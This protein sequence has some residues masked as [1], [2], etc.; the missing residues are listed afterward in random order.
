MRAC[1]RN[2]KHFDH[3]LLAAS[4]SDLSTPR[5]L[6]TTFR[7]WLA[8]GSIVSPTQFHDSLQYDQGDFCRAPPVDH[9]PRSVPIY[10][11]T[12]GPSERKLPLKERPPFLPTT[13]SIRS[14]R[15]I[16]TAFDLYY[17]PLQHTSILIDGH[18]PA[19]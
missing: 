11:C 7:S 16:W 9:C 3:A 2:R 17:H 5:I 14:T 18:L 1:A 12:F 10:A 15:R 4:R 8:Q 13:S 19:F 6:I